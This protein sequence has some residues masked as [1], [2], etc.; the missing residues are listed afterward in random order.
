MMRCKQCD[1][2]IEP[3][4]RKWCS[5]EC[6]QKHHAKVRNA[7]PKVKVRKLKWIKADRAKKKAAKEAASQPIVCEQ[8]GTMYMQGR[9]DQQFCSEKCRRRSYR[10]ANIDT[11]KA[12]TKTW[13]A[14]NPERNRATKQEWND[15]NRDKVREKQ[16]AYGTNNRER[17]RSNARKRYVKNPEKILSRKWSNLHRR[18]AGGGE[19]FPRSD[20]FERDGGI[21]GYCGDT[22]VGR[23]RTVDHMHCLDLA[24]QM[25]ALD[26]GSPHTL[27]NCVTACLSCNCKKFTA[28]P[29][30]FIFRHFA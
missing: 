1:V 26:L 9:S 11:E 4:R 20:V 21:C 22:P 17:M 16:S 7:L 13:R 12:N 30:N 6:C 25:H 24:D 10:L 19:R 23:E 2:A 27:D 5:D 18:R 14:D 15:R 8:C 29:L 28:L 3:P